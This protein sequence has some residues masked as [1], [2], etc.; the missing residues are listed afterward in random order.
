MGTEE[1]GTHLTRL[2]DQAFR[3][4]HP[5]F[6]SIE[7]TYTCNLA[8]YFCYNPVQRKAQH[9]AIPVAERQDRPL[10]F[11]EM[12][13]VLDQLRDLGVLYLTLTG[14]EPLLHPRF[15]DIAQAAK[16]R[17]FAIRIFSNGASITEDVADRL[18]ALTP[19]CLEISIH[20]ARDETAEALTQV[21][22]SFQRQL[23]ALALLRERD[24]RVFLKC[25]VTKLVENELAEIKAMADR[26]GYPIYFDPVL[27]I[28]DDRQ[29]YPLELR[30][31]DEG[32][33]SLYRRSGI[34][35]GNSPFEREPGEFNCS[36]GT[37]V[38]H[39]TPYGDILPCVQWKQPVGNVRQSRILHIWNTSPLLLAAR[40]ASIKSAQALHDTVEEHAFCAHCP[41][42]SQLRTGDPLRPDEQYVRVAKIRAA[43]AKEACGN[44]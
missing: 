33:A 8:C 25:V 10:S 6:A 15:W 12:V 35:I 27:T 43:T 38:L 4:R 42:L 7:L 23:K 37:G 36:V 18:R 16:D 1:R 13:D 11:E 44:S 17:S 40:E 29:L 9:R 19:N 28:S 21:K 3:A 24:V 30:A 41:G 39:I 5:I 32:I 14:G 34:N 20:G 26:F 31:S 2:Y 22:G